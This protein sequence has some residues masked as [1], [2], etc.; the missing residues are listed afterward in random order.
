MD[1]G[2]GTAS[3]R[4]VWQLQSPHGY[5]LVTIAEDHLS[6]SPPPAPGRCA[7]LVTD[8]HGVDPWGRDRSHPGL[9]RRRRNRRH[10]YGAQHAP[11]GNHRPVRAVRAHEPAARDLHRD[12]RG[13][14]LPEVHPGDARATGQ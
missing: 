2:P 7:A 6:L 9:D 3:P 14:W 1:P 8:L 11:D 12:G 5:S 4:E 13:A 10:R